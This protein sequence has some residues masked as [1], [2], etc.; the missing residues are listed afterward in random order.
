MSVTAKLRARFSGEHVYFPDHNKVREA[1]K[2]ALPPKYQ[3][4]FWQEVEP[5]S[6][7]AIDAGI[8]A[9]SFVAALRSVDSSDREKL[10]NLIRKDLIYRLWGIS[11]DSFQILG[12]FDIFVETLYDFEF[13]P[14]QSS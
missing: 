9:M 13:K 5:L 11:N 7:S 3:S 4:I 14:A 8:A 12:F 6:G 1:L 10:V 2:E